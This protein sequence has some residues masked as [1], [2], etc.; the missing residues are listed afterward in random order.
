MK[1]TGII[2]AIVVGVVLLWGIGAYNG[3]VNKQEAVTKAWSQVENV[4]QR[5]ADLV[6]NLVAVVKNYAE[7]EQGTILA[8]T[9]ARAKAAATT[10][11][12]ENYTEGDL[13]N[14][15]NTQ[16]ALGQSVNRLLV[17]VENYPDLKA[18]EEFLTLQAQLAGCENRI[19]TERQR[20]NEAAKVYNASLRK[21][22]NN[23]I[24]NMFG[25]EKRPYFEAEAG[26][27]QVP[28]TF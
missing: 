13:Q 23:L 6:P 16:E 17:A 27:E 28:E 9:E 3:L 10:V 26:A 22:P 15:E 24:S 19:L 7:Y 1:K 2:I 14:Y 21:F 18:N 25:F 5:R 11:N 4:Y 20:F 8:V 12:I